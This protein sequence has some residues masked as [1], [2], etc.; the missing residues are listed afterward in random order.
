MS[1]N[2]YI[3]SR[4]GLPTNNGRNIEPNETV[5]NILTHRSHRSFSEKPV[6]QDLLDTLFDLE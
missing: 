5:T 4:F 1:L 3:E 2:R 6:A